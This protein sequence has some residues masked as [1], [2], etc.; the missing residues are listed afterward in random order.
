VIAEIVDVLLKR[1]RD[2]FDVNG[3]VLHPGCGAGIAIAPHDASQADALI[4]NADLALYQA[5]AEGGHGY[6]FFLPALRARAQ[7]RRA[8]GIELRRACAKGEFE[9][10]FQPQIRLADNAVIGAEAPLRWRHPERGLIAP[11]AFIDALAESSI[12]PEVGRW[13]I[14]AACE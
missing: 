6:R 14:R 1:L 10:N 5:K 9:L 2:P 8:L 11:A 13:I 7:A 4:A 3:N 12:A